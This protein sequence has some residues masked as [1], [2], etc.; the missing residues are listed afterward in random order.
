MFDKT[1]FVMKQPVVTDNSLYSPPPTVEGLRVMLENKIKTKVQKWRSHM[2]T[3]WN[4]LIRIPDCFQSV[5][6]P[7]SAETKRFRK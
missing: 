1:V 6:L 4:R 2:K 7:I 3:I 5:M